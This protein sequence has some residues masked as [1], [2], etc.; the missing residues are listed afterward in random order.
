MASDMDNAIQENMKFTL[1]LADK[2]RYPQP[3]A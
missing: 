1:E 2:I 3:P